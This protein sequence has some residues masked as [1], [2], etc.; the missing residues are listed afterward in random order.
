M[1]ADTSKQL[2]CIL[3]IMA[4][5]KRGLPSHCRGEHPAGQSVRGPQAVRFYCTKCHQHALGYTQSAIG[6]PG[7]SS[8]GACNDNSSGS[9]CTQPPWARVCLTRRSAGAGMAKHG[10]AGLARA[11]WLNMAKQWPSPRLHYWAR[12]CTATRLPASKLVNLVLK[13]T[14]PTQHPCHAKQVAAVAVTRS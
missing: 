3:N 5:T 14:L 11:A 10:K 8:R 4:C 2:Y 6:L 13:V 7:T 1:T 12:N 9:S